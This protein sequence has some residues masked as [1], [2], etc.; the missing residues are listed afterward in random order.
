MVIHKQSQR[1]N[2][3]AMRSSPKQDRLVM[4]L[5]QNISKGRWKPGEQLP[6]VQQIIERFQ[7][8][9]VT[10]Q[11]AIDQLGRDGFVR[12][13]RRQGVFVVDRLPNRHL[14][15]LVF[16]H[17]PVAG[18]LWSLYWRALEQAALEVHEF[19]GIEF[20]V[21]YDIEVD[22][23]DTRDF[24]DLTRAVQ[25]DR[26]A[27]L[28]FAHSP[29]KLAGTPVL[30]HPGIPRVAFMS[31]GA[32]P[33]VTHV[34]MRETAMM[35]AMVD[36][37]ASH[38]RR[39]LALLLAA[40]ASSTKDEMSRVGEFRRIAQSRGLTL[41]ARHIQSVHA[42]SAH[43]AAN[44]V[45]AMVHKDQRERPDGLIITDDNLAV[46]AQKGVIAAGLALP[47]QLQIVS[48][49]NFPCPPSA[50]LPMTFMGL[51]AREMLVTCARI[52]L[53][54]RQGA[55]PKEA[56]VLPH[57]SADNPAC[58]PSLALALKDAAAMPPGQN[59]A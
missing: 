1:Y 25:S 15:A 50:V 20:P 34:S 19:S 7:V 11:R 31:E 32:L 13:E 36:H 2:S 43:W 9:S 57:R 37:L 27:G 58:I 40:D 38:G 42:Q 49:C 41:L 8:S 47:E 55:G 26:L 29:H 28:I 59:I 17:R 16:P 5:R 3:K 14:F 6:T 4:Q 12:T 48:Y 46:E 18:R 54:A 21:F 10:A 24:E 45:E 39:R 56:P 51:D 52:I 22:L 23:H 33:G 35:E 30:D 44:A 53:Q